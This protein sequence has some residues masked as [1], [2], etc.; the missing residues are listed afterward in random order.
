ME[1]ATDSSSQLGALRLPLG[2]A[3]RPTMPPLGYRGPSLVK[4]RRAAVGLLWA[5]APRFLRG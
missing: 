3:N 5:E 4:L 1:M 2:T